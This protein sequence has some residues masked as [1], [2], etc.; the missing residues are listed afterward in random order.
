MRTTLWFPFPPLP[1]GRLTAGTVPHR[2]LCRD[3]LAKLLVFRICS[4][5]L[6]FV[7]CANRTSCLASIGARWTPVTDSSL[8]YSLLRQVTLTFRSRAAWKVTG[9]DPMTWST[10]HYARPD[11]FRFSHA[12]RSS[13]SQ[14]DLHKHHPQALQSELPLCSGSIER[15]VA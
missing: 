6:S 13:D 2:P 12:A 8:Q 3:G 11:V 10:P 15:P 1:M 7:G 9:C 5:N 14:A 4:R